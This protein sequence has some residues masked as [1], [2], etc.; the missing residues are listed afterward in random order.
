MNNNIISN[1][2]KTSLGN[3]NKLPKGLK[4]VEKLGYTKALN[5]GAG[6]GYKKHMELLGDRVEL[7]N[8]DINI[9]EINT[10]PAVDIDIQVVVCNNVLNVVPHD[11]AVEIV[12][13]MLK[14]TKADILIT[15]YEGDKTGVGA[16]NS[17]GCY[18]ANKKYKDYTFLLDLGFELK[19]NYFILKR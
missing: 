11:I 15:V 17:K 1:S 3:I 4:L 8:Y 16:V 7:I 13:T 6:L 18:Q 14:Y 5:Y 12:N 10:L 19:S 2:I 9:K